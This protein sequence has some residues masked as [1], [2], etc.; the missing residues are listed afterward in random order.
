MQFNLNSLNAE[1][2]SNLYKYGQ[3]NRPNNPA[4]VPVR[5][6]T[7]VV[8]GNTQYQTVVHL[9]AVNY[10]QNAGR[11][12]S[13]AMSSLVNELVIPPYSTVDRSRIMRPWPAAVSG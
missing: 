6:A 13:G 9:D 10:M 5:P 3:L 8:N 7:T 4:S 1:Q 12:A 2:I 11:F